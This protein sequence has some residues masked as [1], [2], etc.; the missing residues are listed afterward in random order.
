MPIGTE[1]VPCWGKVGCFYVRS[2]WNLPTSS[3]S[4]EIILPVSSKLYFCQPLKVIHRRAFT[5]CFRFGWD[6]QYIK[7]EKVGNYKII[8]FLEIYA[9][10]RIHTHH[11]REEPS[12]HAGKVS[13]G[14]RQKII[15]TP[16]LGQCLFILLPKNGK[17]SAI[18]FPVRIRIYLFSKADQRNFNR[19]MFGRAAEVEID[20]IGRMLIPEFLQEGDTTA[21]QGGD[22]RSEGQAG[23]LERKSLVGTERNGREA[24]GTAGREAWKPRKIR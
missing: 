2:V 18:N 19:Y 16:G 21:G 1:L 13:Q 3:T 9:D 7:W 24:S 17:K 22:Y 10:W 11:R 14:D 12:F 23:S 20:S 5:P 6:V 15:I 4:P 8:I